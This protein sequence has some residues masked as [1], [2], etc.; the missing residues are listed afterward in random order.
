MSHTFVRPLGTNHESFLRN[1]PIE[2]DYIYIVNHKTNTPSNRTY[3]IKGAHA[4]ESHPPTS[5]H[6]PLPDASLAYRHQIPTTT[7]NICYNTPMATL[8]EKQ[9]QAVESTAKT[10]LVIAGPG[11]GKTH[12]LA[13]RVQFLVEQQN[14]NPE[15]ILCLTYTEAGATTMKKRIISFL[16]QKGRN[17]TTNTF[18]S[19]ASSL[20]EEYP[21]VFGYSRTLRP[22]NDIDQALII[23]KIIDSNYKKGALRSLTSS[24]DVYFYRQEITKNINTLKSEGVLPDQYKTVVDEWEKQFNAIPDEEKLSTRGTRAGKLKTEYEKVAERIKKNKEFALLY[25]EYENELK[26]K[27]VYDYDDMINRAVQGLQT[28]EQTKAEIQRHYTTVLVDEYQDTNGSQNKLLFTLLD[29][30]DYHCFVVG[31]DDQAIQRF[32]GATIENFT[33]FLETFPETIVISLEDNFRSPQYILDSALHLIADNEQ[34][35]TT[36]LNVPQKLLTA[37]G[38]TA[39]R[40]SYTIQQCETDI[41]ER[42]FIVEQI[43]ALQKKGV[44]YNEIAVIT[45]TNNEQE[46]IAN[47]LYA[48]DIPYIMSGNQNALAHPVVL[49]FVQIIKACH[50][51]Q[52]NSA[53][54]ATLLRHPATPVSADDAMTIFSRHRSEKT[55]LYQTMR[56]AI[57]ATNLLEDKKS[58]QETLSIIRTLYQQ[59][60]TESALAWFYSVLR[61]T[62]LLQW[63][64][65]QEN[66]IT[67]LENIGTLCDE[68]KRVQ[69]G[70]PQFTIEDALS[71]IRSFYDLG[72]RLRPR[73]KNLSLE[74]AVNI[75]TAHQSKGKEFDYVFV[76][77]VVQGVW[78]KDRKRGNKLAL[79]PSIVRMETD[80]ED[81]RRLLYVALTRAK[82][83]LT[84]SY[85]QTHIDG[86][87]KPQEK[88]SSEFLDSLTEKVPETTYKPKQL[89][90]FIEK[91]DFVPPTAEHTKKTKDIIQGITQSLS[92]ALSATSMNTFLECPQRFLYENIL[93]VPREGDAKIPLTY[94]SA[95]HYTLQRYFEVPKKN[96]D[97]TF[98]INTFTE[99][100]QRNSPLTE[101]ENNEIIERAQ[102]KLAIYHTTRLKDEHEPL[103]VEQNYSAGTIT[104][105]TIR[106]AGKIDKISPLN[107]SAG[108]VKVVDYKTNRR[109]KSLNEILGKT[110]ATQGYAP[111]YDQLM[112]Y[113][114][115]LSLDSSFPYQPTQF[116]LD[117]VDVSEEVN[118][119]IEEADYETFKKT[120]RDIWKSIQSLSFLESTD[121]FPFCKECEWCEHSVV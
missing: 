20:L 56:N 44:P 100:V 70:N 81:E 33:D 25:Q 53:H 89:D 27:N 83:G 63:I 79:H 86:Y 105:D 23:K 46:G 118:V 102:Q 77:N 7:Q 101:A 41:A 32:Q 68:I 95:I 104:Y 12:I 84:V 87:E 58:V 17:V 1:D 73:P 66:K 14:T 40:K 9:Q 96:R 45:R 30:P 10:T 16:G 120:L 69:V 74:N 85:A 13:S 49:L 113:K 37:R 22:L 121:Q 26:K 52:Q 43:I 60:D 64:G 108:E 103:Y 109:K 62:G 47:V 31:D 72:I 106:L 97:K 50:N 91:T 80:K 42:A 54:L 65:S 24:T 67:F 38:G 55:N 88:I 6:Q 112:F 21:D 116:A 92:F 111:L 34:R 78:S 94:G 11:T 71:H 29:H 18:H 90:R 93:R 28:S 76:T 61:D 98:L 99:H 117:F 19:F 39:R 115:L 8:T 107:D 114:L 4:E 15:N 5:Y 3:D 48:Y 110:K 75:L 36:K 2:D 57:R 59:Q 51:P 119:P 35:I 82:K